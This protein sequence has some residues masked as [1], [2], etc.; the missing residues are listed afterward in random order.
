MESNITPVFN[1]QEKIDECTTLSNLNDFFFAH[2]T[3][4]AEK[5]EILNLINN[6]KQQLKK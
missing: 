6:R 4:I 2:E 1:W 3:E 5:P